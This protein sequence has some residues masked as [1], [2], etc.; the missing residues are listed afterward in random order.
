MLTVLYD[1]ICALLTPVVWAA[2]LTAAV[3]LLLAP[4]ALGEYLCHILL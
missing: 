4:V 3:A 2:K 1:L